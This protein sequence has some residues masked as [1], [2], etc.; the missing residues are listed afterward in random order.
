[1]NVYWV[2]A[3]WMGMALLASLISIR[4]G[5]SVALVEL[6]VGALVGN[7]PGSAHLVQQTEFTNFLATLGSGVLTFLAGAEIDPHSLRRNWRPSLVIGLVSFAAPFAGAL[8]FARGV[9]LPAGAAAAVH[10]VR[11][12]GAGDR[13][14]PSQRDRGVPSRGAQLLRRARRARRTGGAGEVGVVPA[15]VDIL[16]QPGPAAG[17]AGGT[18]GRGG[19]GAAQAGDPHRRARHRIQRGELRG[20][21][22]GVPARGA[23]AV[24]AGDARPLGA[25]RVQPHRGDAVAAQVVH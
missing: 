23:R 15:A 6:V 16:R 19:G 24:A 9:R 11:E 8:L 7:I 3:A 5:I 4:V 22:V 1:M 21:R 20:P 10:A 13:R 2:A 12:V 17:E 18:G 14:R 25:G